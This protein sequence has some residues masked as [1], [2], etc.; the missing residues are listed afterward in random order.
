M[1]LSRGVKYSLM[2]WAILIM[3]AS[4][5]SIVFSQDSPVQVTQAKDKALPTPQENFGDFLRKLFTL[6]SQPEKPPAQAAKPKISENPIDFTDYIHHL[7]SKI[8]LNWHPP[9]D[10]RDKKVETVMGIGPKGEL[11]GYKILHSS[12]SPSSDKAAIKALKKAFPFEPFP[13]GYT[14]SSINVHF[15]FDYQVMGRHKNTEE[16]EN[17]DEDEDV[18]DTNSIQNFDPSL[19]KSH[20]QL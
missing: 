4:M 18:P 7:E 6:Q 19:F 13:A 11:L 14:K 12:G 20:P 17:E 2:A 1:H 5:P 3:T 10:Y 16:E 15:D 9:E 8:G